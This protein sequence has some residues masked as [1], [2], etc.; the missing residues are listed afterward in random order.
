MTGWNNE[1]N[2]RRLL[3]ALVAR[4]ANSNEPM[5]NA[6]ITE[7]ALEIG[8]EGNELHSVLAY[9]YSVQNFGHFGLN[10]RQGGIE[11]S[12]MTGRTSLTRAGEGAAAL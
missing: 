3:R 7:V 10:V 1:A 5:A 9:A 2:A 11:N 12:N 4:G 6:W 8:L